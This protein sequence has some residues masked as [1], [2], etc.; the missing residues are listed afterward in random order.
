MYDREQLGQVFV[1]LQ[2]RVLREHEATD[3]L[4]LGLS[5]IVQPRPAQ[6]DPDHLSV[7]DDLIDVVDE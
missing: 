6:I 7:I 4:H 5:V 2:R 1:Q 3:G